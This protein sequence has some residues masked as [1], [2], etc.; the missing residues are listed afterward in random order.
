MTTGVQLE[1]EGVNELV[2]R[3][4]KFDKDVYKILT[5]EVRA[6]L[7]DVSSYAKSITPG[8]RALRNWGPW[9]LT[10]GSNAQ[11]GSISLVTGTRDLGFDG[12]QVKRG[13]KPR[14][15]RR[16][17]RGRVTSFSGQV[18]TTTAAG[19]IYALAGSKDTTDPFNRHLNRKRGTT[20]PR[21]LTDARN[22]KGPKAAEAITEAIQKA[23]KAVEGRRV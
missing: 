14:A 20:W 22:V 2:N 12:S 17:R 9:N 23:A 6:G 8:G 19:A 4:A 21:T 13:I 10:T 16:S 1:V 7:A 15:V 18:V 11:V 5:K 3:L